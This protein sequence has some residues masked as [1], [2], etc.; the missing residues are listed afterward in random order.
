MSNVNIDLGDLTG[1][2]DYFRTLPDESARAASMAINRIASRDGMRTVQDAIYDQINFPKGYLT[3][4]RL[5]V[6]QYA[7]PTSL[8]AKITARKRATSL[9]RFASGQPLGSRMRQGVRVGVKPNSSSHMQNAWLVR[10]NRGAS[11]DEDNYN[12]GLAIRVKPG[13]SIENKHSGH[14]S[15]LVPNAVALLYGPSVDQIFR[16]V[17]GDVS[18]DIGDQLA[19]EFFRQLRRLTE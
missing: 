12:I 13:E 9:A 15:W 4:D 10:L 7:K 17:A 19:A 6:T 16:Q 8:E 1:T 2:I 5:G 11:K 18:D 3:G 14:T